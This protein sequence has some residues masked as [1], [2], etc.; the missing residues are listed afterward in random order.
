VQPATVAS[1]AAKID[2]NNAKLLLLEL[3]LSD[4]V[5]VTMFG[6]IYFLKLYLCLT[7]QDFSVVV[8]CLELIL[9]TVGYRLA[10]ATIRWLMD[11]SPL[12]RGYR[13]QFM[14]FKPTRS[15]F[16]PTDMYII[17]SALDD[18]FYPLSLR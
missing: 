13:R 6:A 16:L 4:F 11:Q 3:F 2:V 9:Y 5:W 10:N 8:F 12:V 14:T 15:P 17:L 7:G 1:Q 18:T